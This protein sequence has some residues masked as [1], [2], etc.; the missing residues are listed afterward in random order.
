M[1]T[2]DT[3]EDFWKNKY[4]VFKIWINIFGH[5]C[6]TLL[7]ESLVDKEKATRA[8]TSINHDTE[9]TIVWLI[10][11]SIEHWCVYPIYWR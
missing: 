7:K 11:E 10:A 3:N 6:N 2:T 8:S 4:I 1:S 5:S 9:N